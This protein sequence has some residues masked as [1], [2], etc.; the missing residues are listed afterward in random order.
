MGRRQGLAPLSSCEEVGIVMSGRRPLIKGYFRRCAGRGC[1][2]VFGLSRGEALNHN[3]LFTP[4][5]LWVQTLV[6]ML[7]SAQL[8]HANLS[9]A[10]LKGSWL[11]TAQL[12][13]ATLIMTELRG[14]F[15]AGVQLQGATLDYA[16]LQ[17]AGL[18]SANLEGATLREANL[19]GAW[20]V[21]A[22]L[23]GANLTRRAAS[24][25]SGDALD[26]RRQ[27]R[28]GMRGVGE[29]DGAL[30]DAMV[31]GREEP[32]RARRSFRPMDR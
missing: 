10:D 24:A 23:R 1:G 28:L 21:D 18:G 16:G 32:L 6:A 11:S 4:T 27:G 25:R 7:E 15:L 26:R 12:Q 29:P 19:Q 2:H 30:R 22:K 5:I 8:H 9:Y 31:D 3:P 13:G 20:L 14:A 17:G